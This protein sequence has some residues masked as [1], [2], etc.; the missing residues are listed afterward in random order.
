MANCG[1]YRR[2]S[3]DNCRGGWT[4][5]R[6]GKKISS[7][8]SHTIRMRTLLAP[9][10]GVLIRAGERGLLFQN[11]ATRQVSFIPW[12]DVVQIAT[13]DSAPTKRPKPWLYFF[14]FD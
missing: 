5:S 3:T 10:E 4:R 14:D 7:K 11:A 1:Y 2:S 13:N 9:L 6:D 12:D 8:P